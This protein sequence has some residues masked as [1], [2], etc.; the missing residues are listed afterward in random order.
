MSAEREG[1]K[2]AY[3]LAEAAATCGMSIDTIRRA[4]R[5]N[6]L[7]ARYPTSKPVILN[8]E[9]DEWLESKPTEPKSK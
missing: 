2:K 7:T 1:I 6:E 9:L 8:A 5:N 4:L 3:T